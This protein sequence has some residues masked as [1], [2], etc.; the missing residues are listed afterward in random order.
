M[1][2]AVDSAVLAG[3]G[4]AQTRSATGTRRGLIGGLAAAGA[5]AALAGQAGRASAAAPEPP[6]A[7]LPAYFAP[8]MQIDGR[9]L[10]A[11]AGA[12]PAAGSAA[13]VTA[14]GEA[15]VFVTASPCD[16]AV[17]GADLS[18]A[19]KSLTDEASA[20]GGELV[21]LGAAEFRVT[22]HLYGGAD[23]YF[24]L[25]LPNTV[26]HWRVSLGRGSRIAVDGYYDQ[27]LRLT[28]RWR[29][30][31][32]QA[33]GNIIFGRWTAQIYDY[34]KDLLRGGQKAQALG[35]LAQ[36]VDWAPDNYQAQIDYAQL[37]ADD[38]RRTASATVVYARTEDADLRARAARLL[39]RTEP[40]LESTPV[41]EAGEG[42]LQVILIPLEPCDLTLVTEASVICQKILEVPVKIRRLR[43]PWRFPPA[44]RVWRQR[45]A[46]NLITTGGGPPVDFTGWTADQYA[47]AIIRVGRDKDPLTAYRLRR[48]AEDV[49]TRP[50]QV[51]V[52]PPLATLLDT[53]AAYQPKERRTMF[54]GVTGVGIY[55]GDANYAFS[56]SSARGPVGVGIL[57]YDM[58]LAR[59]AGDAHDSRPRV[60]ERLAKEM[61]PATL[62]L[63]GVPRPVDPGDPY[64]YA[65]GVARL[66]EKTLTLSQPTR[67]A[68]AGFR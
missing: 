62:K 53:V 56:L 4:G 64:S 2:D 7:F 25:W 32:A 18:H 26:L 28:N 12:D 36:I 48:F 67:D 37:T 58:M 55:D 6:P 27:L 10:T 35:V 22:S 8:L 60:A 24:V 40:S 49:R 66:D 52:E 33:G 11:L 1:S 41:L 3:A 63:I 57:S 61:I 42:G 21:S 44:S 54:V 19:F 16:G 51:L 17:C 5:C 59:N 9:R 39:G 14:D 50:G 47:E 31:Q 65:N 38:R 34:A 29:F 45:E 15:K 46:R 43:T 68:L 13:Y 20:S 30:E 23:D